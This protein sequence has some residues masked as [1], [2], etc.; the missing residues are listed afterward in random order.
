MSITLCVSVDL[1]LLA[2]DSNFGVFDIMTFDLSQYLCLDAA[3]ARALNLD[4]QPGE[5]PSM[6]LWGFLNQCTTA[7]G[8]RLLGQ[9][10]KQ[11][12]MDKS[13]IGKTHFHVSALCALTR[14][15][16]WSGKISL[17]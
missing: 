13:Q 9:W 11:P 3:A 8:Q 6:C 4:P 1:Q 16:Q 10:L 14:D 15:V 2:T 17:K 7:Q 5:A 12:L